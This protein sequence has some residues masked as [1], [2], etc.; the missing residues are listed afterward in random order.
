MK[1]T[2][3]MIVI[4][5][6]FKDSSRFEAMS[7]WCDQVRVTPELSSRAVLTMGRAKGSI[8]S[9][10]IGGHVQPISGEGLSALWKNAQ[11]KPTKNMASETRNRRKPSRRPRA[12]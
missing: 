1:I 10:P 3:R 2:P 8:G 7:A 5:S 4:V 12:T 9:I 11:K 6:P